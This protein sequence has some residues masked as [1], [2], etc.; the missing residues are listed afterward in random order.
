[1]ALWEGRTGRM[2][3]VLTPFSTLWWL[4]VQ[5]V[6]GGSVGTCT[7]E[8]QWTQVKRCMLASGDRG[9]SHSPHPEGLVGGRGVQGSQRVF[10]PCDLRP[11]AYVEGL[12]GDGGT[13][14]TQARPPQGP[15]HHDTRGLG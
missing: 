8:G 11:V 6:R 10:D 3:R 9:A 13:S 14:D 1:M 2:G 4:R 5:M 12:Q 7:W 15:P